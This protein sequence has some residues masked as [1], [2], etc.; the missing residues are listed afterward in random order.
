MLDPYCGSRSR[1]C[2][3]FKW[4]YFL[5]TIECP[6]P[7]PVVKQNILLGLKSE[8]GLSI[9]Y[10]HLQVMVTCLTRGRDCLGAASGSHKHQV[11]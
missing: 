9:P 3:V 4:P 2:L 11:V 6:P 7:P 10:S 5:A 1:L 8:T